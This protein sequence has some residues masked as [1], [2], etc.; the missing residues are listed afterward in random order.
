MRICIT[1]WPNVFHFIIIRLLCQ[2]EN[3]ILQSPL[4][5]FGLPSLRFEYAKYATRLLRRKKK[6]GHTRIL[7]YFQFVC[8]SFCL[9]QKKKNNNLDG[10]P[11]RKNKEL[12]V[13]VCTKQSKNLFINVYTV[14]M[15][16]WGDLSEYFPRIFFLFSVVANGT[17]KK[18]RSMK[19]NSHYE[20]NKT[21]YR[22]TLPWHT[23]INNDV[24]TPDNGDK[25]KTRSDT[26]CKI[27]ALFG[28]RWWVAARCLLLQYYCVRRYTMKTLLQTDIKL[29]KFRHLC[30]RFFIFIR[31]YLFFSCFWSHI[32]GYIPF[33]RI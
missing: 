5:T 6:R 22:Q 27:F 9:I 17:E 28:C 30:H 29:I 2:Q 10:N 25:M 26:K 21:T 32:A 23:D 1:K 7:F 18:K 16:L 8:F 31:F 3:I 20:F 24:T 19:L 33:L 13:A 4:S 11:K 14:A 12:G 15:R